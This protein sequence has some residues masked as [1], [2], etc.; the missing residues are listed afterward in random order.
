MKIPIT[1]LDE[2]IEEPQVLPM[3][4]TKSKT[5]KHKNHGKK[6]QKPRTIAN[7]SL[8]VTF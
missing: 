8:C 3:R 6:Q 7:R 2:F 4:N 5:V 1:K